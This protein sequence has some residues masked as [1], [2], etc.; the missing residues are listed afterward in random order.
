MDDDT[1]SREFAVF[2]LESY[3]AQVA[4]V[5]SAAEALHS[6]TQ[7]LPDVLLSDITMPS[8]DGYML[9]QQVRTWLSEQGGQLPVI[10]VTAH[11]GE[12]YQQQILAAGYQKHLAKP[13]D[14][15]ELVREIVALVKVR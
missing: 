3:G 4:S 5:S 1:D 10:A 8:M 12:V 2:L 7:T 11:A 14:P 13:V 9:I 15:E 6:L